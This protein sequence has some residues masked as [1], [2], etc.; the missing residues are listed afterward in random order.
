MI[1]PRQLIRAVRRLM[2]E[3][4]GTSALELAFCLP[5]VAGMI[6]PLTDL[7][8][9]AYTQRQVI[10]AAQAGAEY[11]ATMGLA[12]YNAANIGSAVANATGLSGVT[13]PATAPVAESCGCVNAATL[14]ITNITGT[15]PCNSS[16][17]AS[18]SVGTFVTVTAQATYTTL[19]DYSP[20]MPNAVT[21]TA[22][23]LVRIK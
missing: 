8:M 10:N 14:A 6:V 17:C 4:A 9:G 21:L 20:V 19:F 15:P 22:Q 3:R 2:R 1:S 7:G 18:G 5:L 23:S 12:G 13:V 16:S 11:A